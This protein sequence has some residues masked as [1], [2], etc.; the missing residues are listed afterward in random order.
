MFH[1]YT[2]SMYNYTIHDQKKGHQS[3]FSQTDCAC[4]CTCRTRDAM[5]KIYW[6]ILFWRDRIVGLHQWSSEVT[7]V[8]G[9][10]VAYSHHTQM[11]KL[12]NTQQGQKK[13]CWL[14]H[15]LVLDTVYI[16]HLVSRK[17]QLMSQRW[18]RI[19]I[20]SFFSIFFCL[21]RVRGESVAERKN[22]V[23]KN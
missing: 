8:R 1:Y 10:K 2:L 20:L 7:N 4:T 23:S 13:K 22:A 14:V 16:D 17:S 18:Q 19:E 21:E 5:L 3:Q 6:W 15:F 11:V 12:I 9:N